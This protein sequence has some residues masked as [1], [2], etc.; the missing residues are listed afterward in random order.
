MTAVYSKRH[1]IR[2]AS[3]YEEQVADLLNSLDCEWLYEKENFKSKVK[4]PGQKC[5]ECGAPLYKTETVNP[6]FSVKLV[7]YDFQNGFRERKVII[8]VKGGSITDKSRAKI[9][10]FHKQHGK[11]V[12]YVMVFR[13][14]VKLRSLKGKPTVAEWG[15]K[16]GIKVLIG[17]DQ[18]A[19][20]LK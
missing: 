18:L 19:R 17:V 11:D 15:K 12:E 9:T 16:V 10:R 7:D 4:V 3:K 20:Y 8:E 14:N 5:Y 2:F 6:D 1:R 13:N